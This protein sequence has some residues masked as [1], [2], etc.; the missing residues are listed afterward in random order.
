MSQL[1]LPTKFGAAPRVLP[2]RSR[3]RTG[4]RRPWAWGARASPPQNLGWPQQH[5]NHGEK[6]SIPSPSPSP[7]TVQP[8]PAPGGSTSDGACGKGPAHGLCRVLFFPHTPT[9]SRRVGRGTAAY[10]RACPAHDGAREMG[11][12][13]GSHGTGRKPSSLGR[14]QSRANRARALRTPSGT[15]RHCVVN[16]PIGMRL[17]SKAMR[18]AGEKK[19]RRS[20]PADLRKRLLLNPVFFRRP[21]LRPPS[22]GAPWFLRRAPL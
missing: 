21:K 18:L 17:P 2:G 19:R 20:P 6:G 5:D 14:I 8:T 11:H 3:A 1:H 13:R 16:R 22:S 7:S 9:A 10:P 4:S 15:A 12:G